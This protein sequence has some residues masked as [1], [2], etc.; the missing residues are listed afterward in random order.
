MATGRRKAPPDDRASLARG[1]PCFAGTMPCGEGRDDLIEESRWQ[2]AVVIAIAAPNFPD[3]IARPIE[4]V[5]LCNN[6]PGTLVIKAKM[7]F[8]RGGNF[9][10]AQRIG[11]RSM[12]DRENHNDRCVI[13]SPLD[14]KHDHA[15]AVFAP[16][17]PSRFVFVVPQIGI[18]NDKARFGG[19]YRHAPALFGLKHAI[20]MRMPLVHA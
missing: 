7:T 8:N 5:A 20:E 3:I 19:G 1:Q 11:G 17:F 12:R 10:C 2:E 14:R 18:G 13:R 4:F 6:D 16:F 9:N 15:G